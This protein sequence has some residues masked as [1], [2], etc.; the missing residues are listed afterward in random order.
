LERDARQDRPDGD[1]DTAGE[2]PAGAVVAVSDDVEPEQRDERA[3]QRAG[4]AHHLAGVRARHHGEPSGWSA[5][6]LAPGAMVWSSSRG[7]VSPPPVSRG[8][9]P[10]GSLSPGSSTRRTSTRAAARAA[11]RITSVSPS[12]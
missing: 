6:S 10:S 5:A 1:E 2:A 11:V 4:D 3:Q 7:A 9:G 8:S 12:V